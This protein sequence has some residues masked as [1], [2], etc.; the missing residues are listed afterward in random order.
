[1]ADGADGPAEPSSVAAFYDALAPHHHLIFQDWERSIARQGDALDRVIRSRWGSATVQLLDAACGI[2]TQALGLAELGY[3]VTASDISPEAVARARREAG[4]RRLAIQFSVAD[5]RALAA[6]H[7]R[8]FDVVLACD[9]ALPHLL[10]DGEIAAALRQLL[11]CTRPGG[12][13]LLSVRDYDARERQGVHLVPQAVHSAGETRLILFQVWE[14]RGPIYE[15]SLYL[16]EDRGAG[17]CTTRVMRAHSYA[18]G[19]E[20]L[21]ELMRQAGFVS[22]ERIDGRFFQPL[23]A[24]T[25]PIAS[26]R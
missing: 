23:V 19:L 22:V 17:G 12:G 10:S 9:N 13:C 11:L 4:E 26:P 6:H 18:I 3:E 25:R 5:L 21:M 2:G 24:G 7:R 8:E 16:V 1:M 15:L 14:F 20:H